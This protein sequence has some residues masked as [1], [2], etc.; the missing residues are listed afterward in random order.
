MCVCFGSI[1]LKEADKMKRTSQPAQNISALNQLKE[2]SCRIIRIM[3]LF[4]ITAIPVFAVH[5]CAEALSPGSPYILDQ[6]AYLVDFPIML[7]KTAVAFLN[8]VKPQ[9]E[10][11]APHS[12]KIY[13]EDTVMANVL[14][15][16]LVIPNGFSP[17][18]DGIQDTWRIKCIENYP[19]ARVEVFNRW[20]NLVFKKENYGNIDL[21]GPED[22][23]WDGRSTHKWT[24]GKDILPAG[25]YFYIL[26]LKDGSKPRNGF[27]YLNR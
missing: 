22:A 5:P 10:A 21:H 7:D 19:N 27:L 2:E 6:E 8:K 14:S 24:L 23:W 18:N 26:D 11:T 20:G 1:L 4:F 15:C 9:A 16:E 13:R 17:N 12:D 3:L 25:T